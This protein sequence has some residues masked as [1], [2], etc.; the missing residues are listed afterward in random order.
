MKR[1][2]TLLIIIIA[3]IANAQ[4]D[5]TFV[6]YTRAD[7]RAHVAVSQNMYLDQSGVS[8]Q[9]DRYD[10]FSFRKSSDMT[11][12]CYY[13]DKD[14]C[15][16]YKQSMKNLRGFS[17]IKRDIEERYIKID[18]NTFVNKSKTLIIK[19]TSDEGYYVIEYSM[20]K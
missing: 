16:F 20:Y 1:L 11:I 9:Y 6:G 8:S 7:I 19:F 5:V 4:N 14:V 17:V 2:L 15:K 18:D 13:N 10:E 12:I 3:N